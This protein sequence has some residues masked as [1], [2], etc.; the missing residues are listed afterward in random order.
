MRGAASQGPSPISS[1]TSSP[2]CGAAQTRRGHAPSASSV[3]LRPSRWST[4]EQVSACARRIRGRRCSCGQER[5]SSS[6]PVRSPSYRP[7]RS[8][9]TSAPRGSRVYAV[10]APVVP[11]SSCRGPT[12]P[13]T[14]RRDRGAPSVGLVSLRVTCQGSWSCRSLRWISRHVA[15]TY[16]RRV[17]LRGDGNQHG[18]RAWVRCRRLRVRMLGLVL[19]AVEDQDDGDPDERAGAEDSCLVVGPV[20]FG[21]GVDVVPEDE[22]RG[23][24]GEDAYEAGWW[25]V[26]AWCV[27]ECGE[28]DHDGC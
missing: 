8:L 11:S 21:D 9:V 14:T 7:R 23:P 24:D 26:G 25:A 4:P 13:R 28:E 5:V 3:R 19:A 15:L 1:S 20:A 6:P 27:P 17:R 10:A 2:Q 16:G 12:D 18:R 22:A